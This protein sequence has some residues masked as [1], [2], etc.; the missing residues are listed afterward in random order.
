M[1]FPAIRYFMYL[2]NIKLSSQVFQKPIIK[3][4]I[5]ITSIQMTFFDFI[6]T[7]SI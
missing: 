5:Q 2:L 3:K 1:I 6:T 7:M 4:A